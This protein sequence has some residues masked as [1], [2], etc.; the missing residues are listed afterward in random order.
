MRVKN[1]HTPPTIRPDNDLGRKKKEGGGRKRKSIAG[2]VQKAEGNVEDG[3]DKNKK[4]GRNV[5]RKLPESRGI[6]E[7]V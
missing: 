6:I 5:R 7:V 1:H 4:K 2:T 3:E